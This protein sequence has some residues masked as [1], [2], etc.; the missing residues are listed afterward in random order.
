MR[1]GAH[2][3][4]KRI[5]SSIR[6]KKINEWADKKMVEGRKKEMA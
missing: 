5:Q 6:C 4:L 2:D 1:K 3:A